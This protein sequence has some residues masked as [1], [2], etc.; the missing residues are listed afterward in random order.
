MELT[1]KGPVFALFAHD[2]KPAMKT[3]RDE[4][5][6]RI[7]AR[8]TLARGVVVLDHGLGQLT[9]ALREANIL[10]VKPPAS[11]VD[12]KS[13]QEFL[14]QRILITERP[15]GFI[16]DAPVYEYGIVSLKELPAIDFAASFQDNKTAKL[17]S[18]ALSRYGLWAK[19]A[20]YLL[21]LRQ[22]GKH[23]LQALE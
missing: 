4:T 14:S 9:S 13:K 12:D 21:V 3:G 19:G 8:R 2:M 23:Q 17:I 15:D 1:G 6:A 16:D 18:V 5:I 11:L 10:V 7:L 20:K 22:D